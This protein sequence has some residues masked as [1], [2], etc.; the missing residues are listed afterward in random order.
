MPTSSSYILTPVVSFTGWLGPQ[1]VLD[2]GCGYGQWGML[3][4]QHIDYPW[5]I[6][7]GTPHWNRR[8]D[9]IEAWESYRNP[10]WDFAYDKV[11][12]EEATSFLST[13][14]SDT[15]GLALCVEVLEHMTV[16]EGR[17][18]LDNL[19]RVSEH[20]LVTTPDLPLLQGEVCGNPYETHHAWWS[21]AALKEAGAVGRL[22][23]SGATVA[24]FSKSP[25][26]LEFWQRGI[27]LR[28][29]GPLVPAPARATAQWVLHQL[30][31]HPGPPA[32]GAGPAV[33]RAH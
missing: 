13:V 6:H 2:V 21:W 23:A 12:V 8:I 25:N 14:G 18:L 33:E 29:L 17:E 30:G 22:P 5:E 32:A 20:V 11:V 10:L 31:R 16:Q 7:A 9:G 19:K 26:V 27:R 1:S 3:L 4:R 28:A 24:L 15:Y